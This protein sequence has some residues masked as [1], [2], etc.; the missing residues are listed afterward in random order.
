MFYCLST[1][2]DAKMTVA[3]SSLNVGV[4]AEKKGRIVVVIPAFNEERFIASVV[5]QAQQYADHVIVID[6][7]SVDNT[8]RLAVAA[9]AEV[10]RHYQ[11]AGKA[12]ALNKGFR[13]ALQYE[14]DAIVCLDADAQ[15]D[16]SEIPKVAAPVLAG[17]ADVVIG[18]RFLELK[19]DI[20]AW[21][22]VGQHTLTKVTNTLS[23]SH[24]TDSQ[25]GYRAF[26]R[27]AASALRFSSQGLNVESE[28]QFLFEPAG[29]RVVE[30]PISVSYL[31][32]NKRNPV[33]HGLQVLDAMLSLVARRRPL[34]FIALPGFVICLMGLAVGLNV[35]WR[36]SQT[37]QLATG[38]AIIT[39]IL[40]IT[41][42]LLGLS[43][44]MLHSMG[45][46]MNRMRQDTLDLLSAKLAETFAE[47]TPKHNAN[48]RPSSSKDYA[49]VKPDSRFI[50]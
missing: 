12:E 29:L 31:D 11:N 34:F 18:S 47:A 50:R 13:A 9:G 26:S 5:I 42:I 45:H 1:H 25:S 37:Q 2:Q 20:P 41:G 14:P 17:E 21:R 33:V 44:V 35:A 8:A 36:F 46:F 28:M 7:G 4:A 23:G 49:K 22:Q 3:Y 40:F 38:M 30:V 24:V 43:G 19:S 32:G 16:A 6:D 10:I 27:V 15:H 39:A 48:L